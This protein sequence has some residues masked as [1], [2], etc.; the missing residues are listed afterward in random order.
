[1]LDLAQ[2]SS[3][4][5]VNQTRFNLEANPFKDFNLEAGAEVSLLFMNNPTLAAGLQQETQEYRIID[6]PNLE[7]NERQNQTA[8][9][10]FNLD[11]LNIVKNFSFVDITVGRQALS[12]G[13]STLVSPVSIF[14]RNTGLAFDSEYSRGFDAVKLVFPI[15]ETSEAELSYIFTKY[16]KDPIALAR[17]KFPLWI[18]STELIG[19]Y[20][21]DNYLIG[22]SQQFTVKDFEILS[23]MAFVQGKN[24]K[25][26]FRGSWGTQYYFSSGILSSLEYHYN[27]PGSQRSNTDYLFA[28]TEGGVYLQNKHYISLSGQKTFDDLKSVAGSFLFDLEDRSLQ[29]SGTLGYSGFEDLEIQA[30]FNYL[31]TTQENSK[32]ILPNTVSFGLKKHF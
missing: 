31:I 9:L 26:Y 18:S 21:F 7:W 13:I 19:V 10:I 6:L 25:N 20:F 28:Y 17:V 4:G 29:A 23:E 30:A 11:R 3:G 1:M 15:H 32:T 8:F 14:S 27:S 5:L 22:M 12:Y 2:E 24:G 16:A